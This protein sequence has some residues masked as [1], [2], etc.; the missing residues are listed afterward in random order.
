MTDNI[1]FTTVA[2]VPQPEVSSASQTLSCLEMWVDGTKAVKRAFDPLSDVVATIAGVLCCV[3][4]VVAQAEDNS[5]PA[6]RGD[7]VYAAQRRRNDAAEMGWAFSIGAC[8][9]DTAIDS[10]AIVA[11]SCIAAPRAMALSFF[12]NND[13]SNTVF[14]VSRQDIDAVDLGSSCRPLRDYCSS[15]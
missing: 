12:N 7:V 5:Q 2:T 15:N 4:T 3:A 8:L 13:R 14:G 10:V 11:G 9:G 6:T 1:E